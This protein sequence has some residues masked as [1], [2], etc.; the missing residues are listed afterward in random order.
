MYNKSYRDGYDGNVI[1][2]GSSYAD[3]EQGRRDRERQ[4]GEN[5]GGGN[6][7]GLII[8]FIILLPSL[9]ISLVSSLI[10]TPILQFYLKKV[11]PQY[12]PLAFK[13][14]FIALLKNTAIYQLLTVTLSLLVLITLLWLTNSLDFLS[15]YNTF[16]NS[17]EGSGF[18]ILLVPI[19]Y[20]LQIPT[21]LVNAIIIRKQLKEVEI[22]KGREGY[23]KS[24]FISGVIITPLILLT[25]LTL[26]EVTKYI[27]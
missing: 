5:G 24:A 11:H 23:K 4:F 3:F 15:Y 10:A 19:V 26:L 20:I 17:K 21:I 25:A 12:Q 13:K 9:I 27:K 16:I 8:L 2:T 7:F 18:P 14:L 6:G 1:N 22:L